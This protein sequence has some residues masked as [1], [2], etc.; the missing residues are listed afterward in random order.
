MQPPA[1]M[2]SLRCSSCIHL[3]TAG[4]RQLYAERRAID[5]AV[6]GGLGIAIVAEYLIAGPV[7]LAPST[8]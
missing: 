5:L 2:S 3:G 6:A 7:S 8:E 1:F 4:L